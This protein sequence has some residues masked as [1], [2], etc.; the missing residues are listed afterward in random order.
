MT[1][2]LVVG[3]NAK[4][5]I[6]ISNCSLVQIYIFI[7]VC[8]GGFN[9]AGPNR[10]RASAIWCG[11]RRVG[12][13]VSNH[14]PTTVPGLATRPVQEGGDRPVH[15]AICI[16]LDST[17]KIDMQHSYCRRQAPMLM[18]FLQPYLH[19]QNLCLLGTY[20]VED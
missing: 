16:L 15:E 13:M 19:Q 17:R 7:F 5:M 11:T 2:F 10:N 12:A 4:A 20:T 1:S 18:P 6:S 3:V 14:C 8:D 9:D